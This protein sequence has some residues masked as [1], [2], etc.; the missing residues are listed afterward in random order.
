MHDSH[1]GTLH[2]RL[3][4]FRGSSSRLRALLGKARLTQ[5]ARGS[6]T[7]FVRLVAAGC[8]TATLVLFG[9]LRRRHIDVIWSFGRI[10]APRFVPRI[11]QTL[12]AARKT[13]LEEAKAF[14]SETKALKKPETNGE[15]TK[16]DSVQGK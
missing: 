4:R 14:E 3:D 2:G 8:V 11:A 15:G 10:I 1:L 13:F 12:R 7:M 6:S 9:K 5:I 16:G